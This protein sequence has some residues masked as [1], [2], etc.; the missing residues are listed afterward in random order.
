VIRENSMTTKATAEQ[1]LVA[2]RSE[3]K[4]VLGE[5][6]D[7][8]SLRPLIEQLR[9]SLEV[10]RR[11]GVPESVIAEVLEEMRLS[12]PDVTETW[13]EIL[14]TITVNVWLEDPDGN[15]VRGEIVIIDRII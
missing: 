10:V 13:S 1:L 15:R 14:G 2:I 9:D 3:A 7:P 5:I 11:Q 12:N 8:D 6:H 4:A